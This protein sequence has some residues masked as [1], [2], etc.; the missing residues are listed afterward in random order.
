MTLETKIQFEALRRL[1]RNLPVSYAK[2][3]GFTYL[4]TDGYSTVKIPDDSFFLD[5]SK[6]KENRAISDIFNDSGNLY[7]ISG[8]KDLRIYSKG[9]AKLFVSDEED[10]WADEKLFKKL[11]V[12][13]AELFT[14]SKTKYIYFVKDKAVY[15]IL[16]SIRFCKSEDNEC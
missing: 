10:V 9:V 7:R 13:N 1:D 3:D 5:T 2:S 16:L 15:A 6:I 4:T 8:T 11:T 12:S 14:D